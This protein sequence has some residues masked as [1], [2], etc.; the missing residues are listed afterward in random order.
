MRAE[1]AHAEKNRWRSSAEMTAMKRHVTC[2]KRQ[3]SQ[4][5][6]R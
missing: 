1:F 6:K 3:L 5:G 4:L 2:S